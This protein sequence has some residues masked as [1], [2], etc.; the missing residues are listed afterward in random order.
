MPTLPARLRLEVAVAPTA[1]ESARVLF[2]EY[3]RSLDVDLCFQNF[4]S[5]L[6]MLP[7]EYVA[8]RGC[9][10]VLWTDDEP[11][12]CVALRPVDTATGE[13]KRLYVRPAFRG[14]RC[15]LHLARA[16]ISEASRLGYEKLVLDTLPSMQAA[17]RMYASL[18]FV[19]VPPYVYNPIAGSRYMGLDLE[20]NHPQG[21]T[22]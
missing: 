8:P 16:L 18:G 20:P 19:D 9:L 17:Q 10:F 5:E 2:L 7:G 22:P 4:E 15:G 3:Q 13:M 6:A 11:V 1:V 14:Q 21:S 12:G